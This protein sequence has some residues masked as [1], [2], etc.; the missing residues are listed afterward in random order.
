MQPFSLLLSALF[1]AVINTSGALAQDRAFRL[2]DHVRTVTLE[3]GDFSVVDAGE[4]PA[5]VFMHGFPEHSPLTTGSSFGN[6][7]SCEKN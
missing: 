7:L 4:G 5:V 2:E 6:W 1:L 3:V